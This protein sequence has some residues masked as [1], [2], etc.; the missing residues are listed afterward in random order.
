MNGAPDTIDFGRRLRRAVEALE[1]LVL[2]LPLGLVCA[3]V[4]ALLVLGAALSA[5][6]IGLPIVLLALAA[7]ARLA[8]IE[9]R[10]AN[11]LLAAHIAPRGPA[12]HHEGTLWRRA[13]SGLTDRENWRVLVLVATKLPVAV[14]GLAAGLFPVAVTVW[15]LIFGVRGIGHLGDRFYVGPWALGPLTG[16]L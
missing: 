11:R 13:I 14:L 10:Q 16:L 15:L 3:A 1:Y 12:P 5:I 8:E 6:W 9:R 4:T 7:C 2:S